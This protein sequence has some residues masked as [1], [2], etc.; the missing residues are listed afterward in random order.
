MYRMFQAELARSGRHFRPEF[1][2]QVVAVAKTGGIC[3]FTDGLIGAQKHHSGIFEPD[4][5]QIIYGGSTYSHVKITKKI[6]P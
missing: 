1:F 2:A 6:T 3:Y 5:R 4:L